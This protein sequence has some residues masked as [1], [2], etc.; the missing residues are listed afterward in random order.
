MR[1][2][3]ITAPELL[4]VPIHDGGIERIVAIN[5]DE[6]D[7]RCSSRMMANAAVAREI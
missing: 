3:L 1:I 7:A 2:A 5:P 4:A 6:I